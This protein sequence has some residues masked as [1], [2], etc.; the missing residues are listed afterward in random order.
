MRQQC[1]ICKRTPNLL[2][3]LDIVSCYRGGRGWS[4]SICC[5]PPTNQRSQNFT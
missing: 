1:P 4:F 5:K 3:I 2:Y